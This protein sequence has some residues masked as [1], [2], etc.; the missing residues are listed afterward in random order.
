LVAIVVGII[1]IRVYQTIN[2]L[3]EKKVMCEPPGAYGETTRMAMKRNV[4]KICISSVKTN[5]PMQ[6]KEFYTADRN[7]A[8]RSDGTH[9]IVPS[10]TNRVP[11]KTGFHQQQSGFHQQYTG[12]QQ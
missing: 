7:R 10:P 4:S 11:K 6:K 1:R 5:G 8:L 2:I 3:F 12:F 9:S